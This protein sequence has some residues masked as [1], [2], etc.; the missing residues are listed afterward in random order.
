[1]FDADVAGEAPNGAETRM[2]MD[3]LPVDVMDNTMKQVEAVSEEMIQ[4][5]VY[6][7]KEAGAGDDMNFSPGRL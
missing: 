2:S 1:M 3:V 6:A 5:V 4:E 7:S